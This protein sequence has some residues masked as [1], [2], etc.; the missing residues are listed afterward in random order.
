MF[1]LAETKDRPHY[2]YCA[3]TYT[4]MHIYI[5]IYTEQ[6]LM[7]CSDVP[8]S[9]SS[10]HPHMHTFIPITFHPPTLR[11]S[12]CVC[13]IGQRFHRSLTAH[14][15]S[16]TAGLISANA[17]TNRR[18]WRPTP[19]SGISIRFIHSEYTRCTLCVHNRVAPAC[20]NLLLVFV[21]DVG[22]K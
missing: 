4:Y 18:H 17:A 22:G 7:A 6:D 2:P 16:I 14:G 3:Y 12:M 11:Q 5:H 15:S 21:F 20:W 8:P 13:E 10:L 19:R 1:T 9:L